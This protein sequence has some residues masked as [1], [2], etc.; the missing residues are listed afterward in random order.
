MGRLISIDCYIYPDVDRAIYW[1]A[2]QDAYFF[3]GHSSA[4]HVSTPPEDASA[5]TLAVNISYDHT[6]RQ[7]QKGFA[8]R[9]YGYYI[10][11]NGSPIHRVHIARGKDFDRT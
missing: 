1:I 7:W 8:A 10:H 11:G 4:L 6:A 2:G 3:Q 5:F 9:V